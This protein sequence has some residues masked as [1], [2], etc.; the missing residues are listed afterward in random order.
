MIDHVACLSVIFTNHVEV[1]ILSTGL[2]KPV[3]L[4]D[5]SHGPTKINL[6]FR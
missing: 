3:Y 5:Y 2:G 6:Q 1:V 4:L